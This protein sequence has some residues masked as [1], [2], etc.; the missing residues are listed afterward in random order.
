MN[1]KLSTPVYPTR[2]CGGSGHHHFFQESSSSLRWFTQSPVLPPPDPPVPH[3]TG[4]M[5]FF[6]CKSDHPVLLF[7]L[8]WFLTAHRVTSEFLS[9]ANKVLVV[10]EPTQLPSLVP[11][12]PGP[13][14]PHLALQP[15]SFPRPWVMYECFLLPVITSLLLIILQDPLTCQLCEALGGGTLCLLASYPS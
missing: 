9:E 5:I 6:K 11:H 14:S 10:P 1:P 4:S 15:P 3:G 8:Q 2:H 12:P 13:G 7:T